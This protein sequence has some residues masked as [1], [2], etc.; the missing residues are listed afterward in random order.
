MV[1]EAAVV[2]LE[3]DGYCV[4]SSGYGVRRPSLPGDTL[5]SLGTCLH[6]AL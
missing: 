4:N 6:V 3:S 2:V 1:L 5:S